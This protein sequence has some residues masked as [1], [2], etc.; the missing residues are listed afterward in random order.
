MNRHRFLLKQLTRPYQ[1]AL[2][3][4]HQFGD[5]SWVPLDLFSQY[6]EFIKG[7]SDARAPLTAFCGAIGDVEPMTVLVVKALFD[8]RRKDEGYTLF[9][10]CVEELKGFPC[11]EVFRSF[12]LTLSMSDGFEDRDINTLEALLEERAVERDLSIRLSLLILN[13]RLGRDV[14]QM[15]PQLNKDIQESIVNHKVY[16]M[17]DSH[18]LQCFQTFL[19]LGVETAY[20][21]DCFK[22]LIAVNPSQLTT[23]CLVPYLVL[24]AANN[25]TPPSVVVQIL[26]Q[27]EDNRK[28]DGR[29]TIHGSGASSLSLY[30]EVTVFRIL[31][32]CA[33]YADLESFHYILHYLEANESRGQIIVSAEN[34]KILALLQVLVF[35][36]A[37]EL[38]KAIVVAEK[39]MLR[40]SVW[41][42]PEKTKLEVN[43]RRVAIIPGN[44][45]SE[46][47]E[48]IAETGPEGIVSLATE[49]GI[50][51]GAADD[52][53]PL[54]FSEVSVE[55]LLSA[56]ALIGAHE[57]AEELLLKFD[58]FKLPLS[59]DSFAAF[60]SSYLPHA[61]PA[62]AQ[63]ITA[64]MKEMQ[65]RA[66]PYDKPFLQTALSIF[67]QVGD[68]AAAT[69]V[70]EHYTSLGV[71][72]NVKDGMKL[73]RCVASIGDAALL[74]RVHQVLLSTRTPID[75]SSK[76]L[77]RSFLTNAEEA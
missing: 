41:E 75:P 29:V 45:T 49:L 8:A 74:S 40:P 70:A 18:L 59:G 31:V 27:M 21:H 37:G 32:K 33:R 16:T 43:Q 28:G 25:A 47:I 4:L 54:S 51:G 48:A 53:K 22:L 42:D 58:E 39:A 62:A 5:S 17:L 72:L 12:L 65:E 24:S 55:L 3:S 67:L 35:A 6:Q 13:L 68:L 9:L 36:R 76:T 73:V 1:T 38:V 19:R 34:R 52:S 71:T 69:E 26:R 63:R 44:P 61:P 10:Q 15:W 57:L 56:S 60:A 23:D 2:A 11:R 14:Q 46:L 30:N 7:T 20:L 50:F 77:L 64:S 66:I